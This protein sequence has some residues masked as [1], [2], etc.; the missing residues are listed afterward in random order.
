MRHTLTAV[1]DDRGKAQL[2]LAE[3]LACGYPAADAVLT[4]VA[5]VG[6]A[7]P[8]GPPVPAW[9]ERPGAS[10]A[11][12]L[13][14]LAGLPDGRR[15]VTGSRPRAPDSHVLTLSTDSAEDAERAAG[16]ISG[17]MIGS[18]D[19]EPALPAGHCPDM[20]FRHVGQSAGAA[21]AAQAACR[22]GHDMHGNERYRNRA[23]REANADLKVLWEARGPQQPGWES[24]EAAVRLGWDS[25]SP[26]IDDDSYYRSHWRTRHAGSAEGA[27]AARGPASAAPAPVPGD[28]PARRHPGEPTAWENFMDAIR[29]GWSRTRIG[30]DMD[31][32]DYR[33]HHASAYP[34]TNYDDLAPVY[35][36]GHHL[37]S[38]SMFAGQGWDEVEVALRAEWE[39][40]HREG[41]PSTWDE[42]KAALHAGWDR[43]RT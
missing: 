24:S 7:S 5:G 35:R 13:A 30:N 4:T 38:R 2:A 18:E 43:E 32:A 12:L 28:T 10:S 11:R 26:E 9:R 31:E 33:R 15:T 29:H 23:W 25:T 36:Y 8:D 41:K 3:L 17:F 34:G 20:I 40:G 22:F 21:D 42:M 16:L 39:R 6:A 27:G 19:R 14:R 1:F 37:R